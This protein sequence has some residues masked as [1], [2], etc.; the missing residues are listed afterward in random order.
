MKDSTP[1]IITIHISFL[2]LITLLPSCHETPYD[3]TYEQS[4][5]INIDFNA[6]QE[7]TLTELIEDLEIIP[8]EESPASF[9]S[10][11]FKVIIEANETLI[12]DRIKGKVFVFDQKGIYISTISTKEEGPVQIGAIYDFDV[13]R[14]TGKIDLLSPDGRI[15]EYDRITETYT[16]KINITGHPQARSYS[17]FINA[18]PDVVIFYSSFDDYFLH[19]YSIK[20]E[21]FIWEKIENEGF[22]YFFGFGVTPNF[23]LKDGSIMF[24]EFIGSD[25][26]TAT[27]EGAN[28]TAKVDFGRNQFEIEEADPSV[29]ESVVNIIPYLEN[30]TLFYPVSNYFP[31]NN[32]DLVV[33]GTYKMRNWLLW[34][35]TD[36]TYK[37]KLPKKGR[38]SLLDNYVDGYFYGIVSRPDESTDGFPPE[39][40]EAVE[41]L[42]AKSGGKEINPVLF[43]FKFRDI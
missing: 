36:K 2:L 28:V 25:L 10:D 21:N 5:L 32:G 7:I 23:F 35:K 26:I 15:V 38:L 14:F 8:L 30:N 41:K 42:V 24:Y 22:K 19:G 33:T 29:R 40:K 1:K 6:S 13:N 11:V 9:I 39:I 20:Q 34:K 43:R 12:L 17:A 37:I 18:S 27:T 3:D 31:T 16:N 4:G